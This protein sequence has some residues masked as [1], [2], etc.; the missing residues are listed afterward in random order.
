M[1]LPGPGVIHALRLAVH[2]VGSAPLTEAIREASQLEITWDGAANPQIAVPLAAF[3]AAPNDRVEVRGIWSGCTKGRY[4]NYLPMPFAR[5]A[6]I[7]VSNPDPVRVDLEVSYREGAIRA[8][9]GR[10]AACR[11]DVAAPKQGE[12][13][14]IL[15]QRGRGHVVALIMDRPGH[16]EGDDR[17]FVDGETEPSIHGTGTED[18]FNFAWGLGGAEALPFHGITQHF[19][20]PVCYRYLL[21]AGVPYE[22]SLRVTCE[23]GHDWP[24]GPNLHRGRY[25]GVVLLYAAEPVGSAAPASTKE[26]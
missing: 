8:L 19:G 1:N 17:W 4:Y 6:L 24:D 5:S 7:R 13:Y 3:F 10:L 25:S 15:D 23:H 12:D 20:R 22:K 18:F 16:M 11:Y 2:P 21:P 26:K 14:S 9:D